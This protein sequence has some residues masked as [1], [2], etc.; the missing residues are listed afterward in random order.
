VGANPQTRAA[1]S[2]PYWGKWLRR[3]DVQQ[4]SFNPERERRFSVMFD[5]VEARVGK[6]FVALDL[7]SGPGSLSARLLRRFPRARCVAVDFDPVALRV[8]RGALG[9]FGGRLRWVDA[10]LGRPGWIEQL[11]AGR[12]D[13][14]LS[15][16]ALHWLGGAELRQLY[17]DLHG[18]LRKGGVFLDGDR[19]AWGPKHRELSRLAES[20]RRL[21]FRGASLD[22]EWAAWTKWWED[23]QELSELRPLFRLR[24]ERQSQ[25]PKEGDLP[26]DAH[27]RALRRAGFREV[28]VVWQDLENR[29]LFAAR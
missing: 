23:A 8:G 22:S 26:L 17:R 6:R 11:P 14:A 20:V 10:R 9:S 24:K 1:S 2:E 12:Y 28:A 3:W 21:R 13:V 25:H 5:V 18:L 29:V 16:T 4:E 27:A 7:G 19:L 15:T